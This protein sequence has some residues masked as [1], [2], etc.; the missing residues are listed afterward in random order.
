[1]ENRLEE[2]A[3]KISQRGK[4]TPGEGCD[5]AIR[6]AD[7][8]YTCGLSGKLC[9]YEGD[10]RDCRDKQQYQKSHRCGGL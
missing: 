6:A 4:R 7:N 8:K 2:A 5:M 9:A 10:S 1:M 3:E